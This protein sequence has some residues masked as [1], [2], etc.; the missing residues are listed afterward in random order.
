VS[1]KPGM[2]FKTLLNEG[3]NDARLIPILAGYLQRGDLPNPFAVK[4][5]GGS[6]NV[7]PDDWFHPSGHP[8]LS[9]RQLYLYITDP[10]SWVREPMTYIGRMSTLMG[11]VTHEIV[12]TALADC[13]YLIK[14]K[15]ICVACGQ[16]QPR[17]CREHGALDPV[18]RSRGHM[19]G[20][21]DYDSVQRGFEFKTAMP[22]SLR[23]VRNN[24]LEQFKVKW[25][26]YYAQVQEYMRMTGLMHYVVIFMGM[27]NPWILREF[28]IPYDPFHAA[29][30]AAKYQRVRDAVERKQMPEAC[31][32]AGSALSKSCSAQSC[33][34]KKL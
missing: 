28:H 13:G 8:L 31:C 24:D 10:H 20:L 6:G 17:Q 26:K 1:T 29:G 33:P 12:E 11:S 7:A 14:P 30:I 25:P 3:D 4:V 27:G 9:D 34:V 18:L 21:L 19:D 32:K 5:R 16:S 2:L 15:G 23:E 22:M